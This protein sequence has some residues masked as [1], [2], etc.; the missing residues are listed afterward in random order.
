MVG[1]SSIKVNIVKKTN[2][3]KQSVVSIPILS[4]SN[5]NL[6][7]L[8]QVQGGGGGVCLQAGPSNGIIGNCLVFKFD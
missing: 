4:F 6:L 7:N 2:T 5:A 8:M 1:E 3:P